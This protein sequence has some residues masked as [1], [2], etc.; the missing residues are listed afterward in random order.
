[1]KTDVSYTFINKAI[2]LGRSSFALIN[3]FHFNESTPGVGYSRGRRLPSFQTLSFHFVYVVGIPKDKGIPPPPPGVDHYQYLTAMRS[4]HVDVGPHRWAS[5]TLPRAQLFVLALRGVERRVPNMVLQMMLSHTHL[6]MGHYTLESLMYMYSAALAGGLVRTHGGVGTRV[7]SYGCIEDPIDNIPWA[8]PVERYDVPPAPQSATG[9]VATQWPPE[10]YVPPEGDAD[11]VAQLAERLRT[12]FPNHHDGAGKAWSGEEDTYPGQ[13]LDRRST[14]PWVAGMDACVA[15]AGL[16]AN[17]TGRTTPLSPTRRFV[18]GLQWAALANAT[19]RPQQRDR[20]AY[21]LRRDAGM[22]IGD[23]DVMPGVVV[24]PVMNLEWGYASMVDWTTATSTYFDTASAFAEARIPPDLNASWPSC[25]EGCMWR[26]LPL[27]INDIHPRLRRLSRPAAHVGPIGARQAAAQSIS[28]DDAARDDGPREAR[29]FVP[30]ATHLDVNALEAYAAAEQLLPRWTV[31]EVL[32]G[33]VGFLPH[34]DEDLLPHTLVDSIVFASPGDRTVSQSMLCEYPFYDQPDTVDPSAQPVPWLE[35][36]LRKDMLRLQTVDQSPYSI[37]KHLPQPPPTISGI[38]LGGAINAL[39]QRLFMRIPP[40]PVPFPFVML[41]PLTGAAGDGWWRPTMPRAC[42]N[43]TTVGRVA[44]GMRPM[45][46]YSGTRDATNRGLTEERP[47]LAAVHAAVAGGQLPPVDM[48]DFQQLSLR[49]TADVLNAADV[50]LELHGSSYPNTVFLPPGGLHVVVQ[51]PRSA[52]DTNT[53]RLE[54]MFFKPRRH[55]HG[56]WMSPSCHCR[57]SFHCNITLPS[58]R[59]VD[60]LRWWLGVSPILGT[61]MPPTLLPLMPPARSLACDTSSV[62]SACTC[63]AIEGLI[64]A[65]VPVLV[66]DSPVANSSFDFDRYTLHEIPPLQLNVE[67]RN[68]NGHIRNLTLHPWLP[69]EAF[70]GAIE[71]ERSLWPLKP[72]TLF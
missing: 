56:V 33:R 57:D 7:Q 31:R 4:A 48:L 69:C 32:E 40:R 47:T 42:A 39:Y 5:A 20:D 66:P 10:R 52:R 53:F 44:Y 15:L 38:T 60:G 19:H 14:F 30:D 68:P 64:G 16:L 45:R 17:A 54:Y 61:H 9:D 62:P 2:Y 58:A 13:L 25:G 41:P 37:V 12:S 21:G 29:G 59:F 65:N 11:A 46:R 55:R 26:P 71:R 6:N 49:D 27:T 50:Y 63:P 43:T 51:N 18:N 23:V 24:M 72:A 22:P 67:L 34:D 3:T 35:Q 36:F 8:A 28:V 70:P 1:M